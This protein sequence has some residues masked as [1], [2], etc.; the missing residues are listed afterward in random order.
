MTFCN[1]GGKI[2]A[3][4]RDTKNPSPQPINHGRKKALFNPA[5]TAVITKD[6]HI[7][8]M[9]AIQRPLNNICRK[10]KPRYL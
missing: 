5:L 6:I 4:G 10:F 7:D 2:K 1:R 9:K 8:I 3:N